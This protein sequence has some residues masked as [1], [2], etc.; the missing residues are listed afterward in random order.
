[1]CTEWSPA[2]LSSCQVDKS[3]V[4]KTK[5]GYMTLWIASKD[6]TITTIQTGHQVFLCVWVVMNHT[7]HKVMKRE[8]RF[9][10]GLQCITLCWIEHRFGQGKGGNNHD[11][12]WIEIVRWRKTA[13]SGIC[14]CY[15]SS[16]SFNTTSRPHIHIKHHKVT[17]DHIPNS[18]VP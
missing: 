6:G 4:K 3:I 12:V 15:S 9:N 1:M 10:T 2:N 14:V 5:H 8:Q 13:K 7:T 17:G 11:I 16:P 18:N